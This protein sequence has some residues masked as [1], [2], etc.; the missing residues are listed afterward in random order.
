[1]SWYVVVAR[2]RRGPLSTA[3]LSEDLQ[4]GRVPP[5]AWAWTEGMEEWVPAGDIP[6]LRPRRM[7][8]RVAPPPEPVRAPR[9]AASAQP[10]AQKAKAASAQS[11]PPASWDPTAPSLKLQLGNLL[12]RHWRG[13]LSL[14][15][16][17]WVMSTAATLVVLT[18][19]AMV[20]ALDITEAPRPVAVIILAFIALAIVVVIWQIVGVWRSAENYRARGGSK[21]WAQLAMVLVAIAGLRFAIDLI[22]VQVPIAKE[23]LHIVQGDD[24]FSNYDVTVAAGGTQ[25]VVNGAIG[26]GLTARVEEALQSSD[27][28]RTIRFNSDG[29]RLAEAYR[30]ADTIR[31]YSLSTYVTGECSSACVIAF[32]T[33]AER[34]LGPK[35]RIG[36]HEISFRGIAPRWITSER[37]RYIEFLSGQGV[38]SD[39]VDAAMRRGGDGMWYPSH[40]QLIDSGIASAMAEPGEFD[41]QLQNLSDMEPLMEPT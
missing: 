16:S 29:G 33:G 39:F 41:Q 9:A 17:Y 26:F 18:L 19:G 20:G 10:N 15:V 5:D 31:E 30:L 24:D 3:Q 1:M 35:A 2:K 8:E 34:L 6:E 40:A 28:I 12:L 25:V 21:F 7:V 37:D 36:L 27:R 32:A 22:T 11:D 14:P 13:E 23:M 4:A 38:D